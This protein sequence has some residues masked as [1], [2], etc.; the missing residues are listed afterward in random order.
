MLNIKQDITTSAK[1]SVAEPDT[2]ARSFDLVSFRYLPKINEAIC[3]VRDHST[4]AVKRVL[5][6][7]LLIYSYGKDAY[8]LELIGTGG[9]NNV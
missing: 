8:L 4:G 7:N 3:A 2:M 5:A 9:N 6:S 1:S